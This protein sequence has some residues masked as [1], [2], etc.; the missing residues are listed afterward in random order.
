MKKTVIAIVNLTMCLILLAGCGSND[1]Y[2]SDTP[3]EKFE[4]FTSITGIEASGTQETEG[5]AGRI[6]TYIFNNDA[7]GMAAILKYE[8]YIKEYGFV[9]GESNGTGM[10]FYKYNDEHDILI[11]MSQP[12]E[13]VIQYMVIVPHMSIEETQKVNEEKQAEESAALETQQEEEYMKLVELCKNGQYEEAIEC[14]NESNLSYNDDEGYMRHYKDSADYWYYCRGMIDYSNGEYGA[15]IDEFSSCET[16][17][18]D[19]DKVKA[20]ILDEIGF[21]N[22][23]Y[24]INVNNPE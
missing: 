9:E 6:Y 4:T 13:S 20:D 22:G 16:S 10:T 23:T 12:Q 17:V 11:S 1:K 3:L 14:F 18:L 7:D 21:L 15:A 24:Q 2:Y 19:F 5:N 8:T